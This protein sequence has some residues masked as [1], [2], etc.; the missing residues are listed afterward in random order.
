MVNTKTPEEVLYNQNLFSTLN[1]RQISSKMPHYEFY[2][3]KT[4]MEDKISRANWVF[5]QSLSEHERANKSELS[6]QFTRLAASFVFNCCSEDFLTEFGEELAGFNTAD[7]RIK[8]ISQIFGEESQAEKIRR[9]KIKFENCSRKSEVNE[10][11]SLFLSKLE[12]IASEITTKKDARDYIID[13]QFR[14]SLSP[15]VQGFLRDNCMLDKEPKEI[16][17]Y[18]DVRDRHISAPKIAQIDLDSKIDSMVQTTSDLIAKSSISLEEQLTRIQ[19]ENAKALELTNKNLCNQIELLSAQIAKM[20][21]ERK[22]DREDFARQRFQQPVFQNR[23][24]PNQGRGFQPKPRFCTYCKTPD[25]YR[26]N[27]PH[28]TCFECLEKGH[29]KFNC[30]KIKGQSNNQESNGQKN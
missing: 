15:E 13:N 18:L 4:I 1:M 30:P 10:K 19:A 29:I 7:E 6:E 22:Q 24:Q 21:V 16:A 2:S 5:K 25:H 26:S 11:F 12:S 8:F 9:N 28:I 23:N 27:C 14:K 3:Q 20:E 17:S